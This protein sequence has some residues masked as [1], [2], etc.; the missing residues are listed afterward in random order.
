L[1]AQDRV[2]SDEFELTHEFL[3]M[4]LGVRRA[5]VSEAVAGLARASLID[6]SRGRIRVVNRPG[7]ERSSCECYAVIQR[8]MEAVVR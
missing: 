6:A 7:L 3:S 1:T 8:E 2:P 4:M 5:G